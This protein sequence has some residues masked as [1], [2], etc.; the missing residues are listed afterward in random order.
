MKPTKGATHYFAHFLAFLDRNIGLR[1]LFLLSV[2]VVYSLI[3]GYVFY[4][5]ETNGEAE[6]VPARKAEMDRK[7]MEIVNRY[8]NDNSN[9][10]LAEK[11]AALK[12]DYKAILMSDGV[13]KWSTYY[14]TDEPDHWKWT[15]G[16]SFFYSMNVY[17]TVG[18]GSIAPETF[19]A[20]CFT[21]LY[22]TLFC[23]LTWIIIRDLGQLALVYLTTVYARLKLRFMDGNEKADQLYMLPYSICVGI[24][25][26]IMVVGSVWVY[27]YD[28][29]SGPPDTGLDW[30]LSMYFTFQTFTTIGLGD[31]MPNNIPFS[32]ILCTVFFF[33]LPMLKVIN[34]LSYLS[35]ENGVHGTFAVLSKK[36]HDFCYAPKQI[37]PEAGASPSDDEKANDE[38]DIANQ[39]T[40]HSIATF[41][42]SNADV[43][44]G[45]LG[46]VNLRKS[47]I[48]DE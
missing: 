17:T 1:H 15:L 37:S 46:R 38:P 48:V 5:F 12:E 28:A 29:L 32:P 30:F 4:Y 2:L 44:G 36:L 6:A 10:T 42:Q 3:G 27:Y 9:L 18:Y 13:F 34:R 40:I 25:A 26:V 39:L 24:C 7:I 23:P 14:K 20:R 47:D 8:K 43:F 22:G 35:M 19:E 41:M 31:V 11:A 33:S 45:Q 16:S 21:M